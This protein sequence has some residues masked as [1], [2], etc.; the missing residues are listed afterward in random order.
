MRPSKNGASRTA[1][2]LAPSQLVLL[3]AVTALGPLSIDL[4]LPAFPELAA[5]LG[6]SEAA[7][8]LTL[9]AC[10]VGLA[11]GQPLAGT[12]SDAF[13]RRLPIVAGLLAWS[14]ASVACALAPSIATL[15][16]LRLTQGLAGSAGVVVARAVLRDSASG[17]HLTRAFARL[18]LVVGVVPIAA[19]TVG[20]LLLH[21][22]D[23]RGLFLALGA[24]GA[25]LTTLVLV[26]LRETLPPERR[27]SGGV[28]QALS[29]YRF[30]LH[31]AAF[32]RPAVVV[33]LTFAALFTYVSSSSFLLRET[34]GLSAAQ[35]GLQFGVNSVALVAG[36][37]LSARL[38]TRRPADSLLRAALAVGT[39]AVLVMLASAATGTLGYS[40]VS[41]PLAVFVFAVGVA[42]PVA[43]AQAMNG[44]PE[45]AG[46]A[47]GLLGVFQFLV[48]GAI[49][50]LVGLLGTSTAVPFAAVIAACMLLSVA[51]VSLAGRAVNAPV[52]PSGRR[53]RA[54]GVVRLSR[55]WRARR[56]ERSVAPGHRAPGGHCPQP[57]PSRTPTRRIKSRS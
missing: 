15:T 16:A 54:A 12:I 32:V 22:T 6:S 53:R 21:V 46:A 8:Q 1:A 49:A 27:S 50:P 19:P 9:T 42:M 23:W 4:Y 39:V 24:A 5:E 29:G 10:V 52:V 18:M 33:S 13:G 20:G 57:H 25:A 2:A 55:A 43:T 56:A 45:R 14:I 30:L 38:A 17:D 3:G 31:D 51:V 34:F 11:I 40:G 36:T 41:V 28:G 44:H 35:F 7:V 48:G 37:Q 26:G 47:S